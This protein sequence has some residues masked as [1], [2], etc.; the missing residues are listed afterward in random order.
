M[1]VRP[2]LARVLAPLSAVALLGAC[3]LGGTTSPSSPPAAAVSSTAAAPA[4]G[5]VSAAAASSQGTSV[6]ATSPTVALPVLAQADISAGRTKLRVAVNELRASGQLMQLTFT[7]TNTEP[8]SVTGNWQVGTFFADGVYQA[9]GT[10]VA[11]LD[12]LSVDGVY[13]VDPA[14]AKRYLVART[15]DHVCVCTTNT[16]TVFVGPGQSVPLTATFK[17]PPPEVTT[18]RVQIPKAPAFDVPVQR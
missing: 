7:V 16:S 2:A 12:G 18:L 6:T 5:S 17:A 14:N 11:T 8:E 15:P 10:N 3:S 9:E 13:L 4:A 1:S